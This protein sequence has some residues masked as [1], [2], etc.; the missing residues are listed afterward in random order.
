LQ[1]WI[2]SDFDDDDGAEA[3][4]RP[5]AHAAKKRAREH[6]AH[7]RSFADD[8]ELWSVR[9]APTSTAMLAVHHKK[10]EE[11]KAWV[12]RELQSDS[13]RILLTCSMVDTLQRLTSRSPLAFSC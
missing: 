2:D 8:D 10:V 12:A 1:S 3:A 11:V 6:F 4:D 9:H 13:V 7:R 5:A